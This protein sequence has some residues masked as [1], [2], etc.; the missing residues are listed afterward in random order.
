MIWYLARETKEKGKEGF[1]VVL[2]VGDEIMIWDPK[3]KFEE[4]RSN[5]LE[6]IEAALFLLLRQDL[7]K[8]ELNSEREEATNEKRGTKD[9]LVF[10]EE[11][12]KQKP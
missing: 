4:E 9:L 5:E 1:L 11:E 12:I 10:K 2:G 7:S 6:A 3:K 8:F